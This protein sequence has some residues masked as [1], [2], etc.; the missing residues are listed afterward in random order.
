MS[1]E[2][3]IIAKQLAQRGIRQVNRIALDNSL[4]EDGLVL[5]GTGKSNNPYDAVPSA[6]AANFNTVN[7][8]INN[9]LNINTLTSS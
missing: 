7:I 8:W 6:L 4:F 1:E 2:L 9:T 5:S 3:V